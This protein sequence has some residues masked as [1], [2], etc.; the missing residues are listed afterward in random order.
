MEKTREREASAVTVKGIPGFSDATPTLNLIF[1]TLCFCFWANA[2]GLLGEGAVLAIG[3]LQVAVFTGYTVGGVILLARG[4]GFGGNIFMV[5]A[6]FFGAAGGLTH[7]AMSIAAELGVAFNYQVLGIVFIVGGLFLLV[8]LPGVMTAPKTDFL[9]F[10]TGGIGV[11]VFGLTG[12]EILPAGWNVFAGWCLFV[13][14]CIGFWAV[15]AGM[16]SFCGIRL[17]CG[18]PFFREKS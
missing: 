13:D 6:S 12:A 5:F 9:S 4:N 17:S 16:L 10:L 14:G 18:K 2:L 8:C 1:V 15:T 3:V 11:L 7:V